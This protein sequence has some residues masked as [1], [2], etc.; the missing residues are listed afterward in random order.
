M[1]YGVRQSRS[2]PRSHRKWWIAASIVIVA[3]IVTA[4]FM[5]WALSGNSAKITQSVTSPHLTPVAYKT[6]NGKYISLQYMN[7]YQQKTASTEGPGLEQTLLRADTSYEKTLAIGVQPM[8]EGGISADSGY[9]Y[10]QQHPDLYQSQQITVAGAPATEWLKNDGTEQT[11]YIGHGT[12]YAVISFS[13][14]RTNDTA[15][16]PAEVTA[17]LQSFSWK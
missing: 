15:G 16:L 7:I 6:Y 5:V 11:V 1:Q 10:R 17:L 2:Q 12:K 14:D 13:L 3:G 8:L 4:L 9:Q